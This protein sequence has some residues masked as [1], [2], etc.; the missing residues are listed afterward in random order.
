MYQIMK[1]NKAILKKDDR[2]KDFLQGFD[3]KKSN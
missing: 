1:P 2:E 3:G